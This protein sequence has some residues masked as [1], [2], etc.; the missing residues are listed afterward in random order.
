MRNAEFGMR[1]Y[2]LGI[3]YSQTN[4]DYTR[5]YKIDKSREGAFRRCGVC[6]IAKGERIW[7]NTVSK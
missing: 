7:Y 6:G 3:Y 1:N 5:F 2:E 4:S